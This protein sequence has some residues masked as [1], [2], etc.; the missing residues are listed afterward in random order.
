MKYASPKKQDRKANTPQLQF[1]SIQ[2][3]KQ[4][5]PNQEIKLKTKV[6]VFA[7]SVRLAVA[8]LAPT[9]PA[10]PWETLTRKCKNPA[11]YSSSWHRLQRHEFWLVQLGVWCHFWRAHASR[12]EGAQRKIKYRENH[13][14]FQLLKWRA[15]FKSFFSIWNQNWDIPTLQTENN[16]SNKHNISHEPTAFKSAVYYLWVRGEKGIFFIRQNFKSKMSLKICLGT[17]SKIKF[18]IGQKRDQGSW[19]TLLSLLSEH[20]LDTNNHAWSG[21]LRHLFV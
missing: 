5:N 7:W 20:N 9:K 19:Q 6:S 2:F 15:S 14:P 17:Q 8:T 13:Q 4:M 12:Q 10:P 1:S 21:H 3:P 11:D 18:H 16:S